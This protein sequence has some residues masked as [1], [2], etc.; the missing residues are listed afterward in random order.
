MPYERLK[1]LGRFQSFSCYG[2]K[3]LVWGINFYCARKFLKDKDF[4]A[5]SEVTMHTNLTWALYRMQYILLK[6]NS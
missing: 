5:N 6:I 3:C 4:L 1:A 2:L